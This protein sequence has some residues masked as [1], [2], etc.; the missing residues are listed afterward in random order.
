MEKNGE[1]WAGP[2]VEEVVGDGES[3]R[4]QN[5]SA[6][7]AREGKEYG[8]L[9]GRP[10]CVFLRPSTKPH[11]S[12]CTKAAAA[13]ELLEDD[14]FQCSSPSSTSSSADARGV[15]ASFPRPCSRAMSSLCI[16][17]F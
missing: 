11:H 13:D 7:A 17:S 1:M 15:S 14:C 4:C 9:H 3:Q 8:D 12:D 10:F 16:G 5:A 6:A 2:A